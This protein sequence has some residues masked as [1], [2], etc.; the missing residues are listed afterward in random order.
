MSQFIKSSKVISLV[1]GFIVFTTAALVNA[2]GNDLGGS[3]LPQVALTPSQ[4]NVVDKYAADAER[5]SYDEIDSALSSLSAF[6]NDPEANPL[7][8]D[9]AEFNSQSLSSF[10]QSQLTA[11]RSGKLENEDMRFGLSFYPDSTTTS[12]VANLESLNTDAAAINELQKELDAEDSD[13]EGKARLNKISDINAQAKTLG[14]GIRAALKTAFSQPSDYEGVNKTSKYIRQLVPSWKAYELN[15]ETYEI[16]RPVS[17]ALSAG[18]HGAKALMTA[19]VGSMNDLIHDGVIQKDSVFS[20][21]ISGLHSLHV[22]ISTLLALNPIEGV[23]AIQAN[24]NV[25]IDDMNQ[26]AIGLLSEDSQELKSLG[27]SL[28]DQVVH[29]NSRLKTR[30]AYFQK[31]P[32]SYGDSGV[33][34]TRIAQTMTVVTEMS[35]HFYKL[36]DASKVNGTVSLLG[37]SVNSDGK[38]AFQTTLVNAL[39]ISLVDEASNNAAYA[40]SLASGPFYRRHYSSERF[41]E[42][43]DEICVKGMRILSI[44]TGK[45]PAE[46]KSSLGTRCASAN[47]DKVAADLA[48]DG[49]GYVQYFKGDIP[50]ADIDTNAF[51]N[52]IAVVRSAHNNKIHEAVQT[53]Y[54]STI[55]LVKPSDALVDAMAEVAAADSAEKR[56]AAATKTVKLTAGLGSCLDNEVW[57]TK[58]SGTVSVASSNGCQL[59][60]SGMDLYDDD[61]TAQINRLFGTPQ[62]L[63]LAFATKHAPGQVDGLTIDYVEGLSRLLSIISAQH[64]LAEGIAAIS[65]EKGSQAA[66]SMAAQYVTLTGIAVNAFGVLH[67]VNNSHVV[68]H[69]YKDPEV[70]T[71]S[72]KGALEARVNSFL[73]HKSLT[74][75]AILR[76]VSA[77]EL[78]LGIDKSVREGLS[79]LFAEGSALRR[80][81]KNGAYLAA[82]TAPS[83]VSNYNPEESG[84]VATTSDLSESENTGKQKQQRRRRA[85][86]RKSSVVT[87][88]FAV[89]SGTNFGINAFRMLFE[90]PTGLVDEVVVDSETQE[91]AYVSRYTNE[92]MNAAI[93]SSASSSRNALVN[94]PAI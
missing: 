12:S 68:W 80:A 11:F 8:G 84:I 81:G 72:E 38:S 89:R 53:A 55:H 48:K 71:A 79:E 39:R 16:L 6:A 22:R 30:L 13:L 64:N 88:L 57:N 18:N 93:S 78:P 82:Y 73:Q 24:G 3:Y 25:M 42:G 86:Q 60:V 62:Q 29:L 43:S 9:L 44:L 66:K 83:F 23:Q 20:G 58:T 90:V 91:K 65:N 75:G 4:I 33:S 27:A 14:A 94:G 63:A 56:E 47:A 74:L 85:T 87:D 51:E 32:G 26:L 52:G 5:A 40:V 7:T 41:V 1:L 61:K 19:V 50:N 70:G 15:A 67:A 2:A 54:F 28:V 37:L 46:V 76:G 77:Y 21:K 49:A 59:K 10:L 69:M 31:Y 35:N 17:V 36:A 34:S 45:T 92:E